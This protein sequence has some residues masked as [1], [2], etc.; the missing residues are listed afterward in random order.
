MP[1]KD[2]ID[3]DIRALSAV[4]LQVDPSTSLASWACG[5]MFALIW[6]RGDEDSQPPSFGASII[7][8][9]QAAIERRAHP[10]PQPNGVPD[11]T[12]LPPAPSD[13]ERTE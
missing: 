4:L 10:R 3:A 12:D 2:E 5:A 11:V 6:A 7:M 9:L 1:T 8:E 13:A